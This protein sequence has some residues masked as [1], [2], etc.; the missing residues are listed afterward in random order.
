[1]F[2]TLEETRGLVMRFCKAL[3]TSDCYFKGT[4]ESV[5]KKIC[6][7]NAHICDVNSLF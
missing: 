4:F 1:M 2:P 5:V 6:D 7:V 3:V